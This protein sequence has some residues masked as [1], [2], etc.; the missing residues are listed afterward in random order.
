MYRILIT[1]L[2][3]AGHIN[4]L[5]AIAQALVQDGHEIVFATDTSYRE[6]LARVGL[7]LFALPYP[8]GWLDKAMLAFAK[9]VRWT[10]Q[11]QIKPPQAY[12]FDYLDQLTAGVIQLIQEYQPHVLLTDL[13]FYGGAIA[14]D[15]RGL[16]YASFCAIVNT[17]VTDDV[18]PY[19]LGTDWT[20]PGDWRRT[21]W[22]IVRPAM[23]AVLWRHDRVINRVR[24]SYGLAPVK[25]GLLA[26]SPYLSL[27]P[28][29]E[30]Y[31]YPRHTVPSQIMYV[32]PVTSA[33]RG[34]IVDDFPWEWLK[35]E[36]PTVYVSM[37]TVVTGLRV[38]EQVVEA[39]R[40]A[41]WKAVLAIGR[42][43]SRELFANAPENVVVCNY[44]PQ[45]GLLKRVAAVVCHGGN[46][47]VTDTLLHGLPLVVIPISA[48]QPESAARV[49][50]S[51][52]GIRMRPGQANAKRLRESIDAILNDTSYR[53]AAQRIQASYAACDGPT[54]CSQLIARLAASGQSVVRPVGMEPTITLNNLAKLAIPDD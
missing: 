27:V 52:A 6:Q 40:G 43:T 50:A 33:E 48:D 47:T 1:A 41:P 19:G 5:L 45:L 34:E 4:P 44:V 12:F 7:K 29:T 21:L 16:P 23:N 30:A 31:E 11:F 14:A 35:D 20:A 39:A 46:N 17:L 28:T 51:G 49:K 13:N 36:R 18:P 10:T 53:Q 32:G 26:H 42:K 25:G 54:T 15:A 8:P 3:A 9:P 38:F 22:R 37:G 24:R 2:P